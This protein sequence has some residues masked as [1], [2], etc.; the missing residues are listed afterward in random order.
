M[1]GGVAAEAPKAG[2]AEQPRRD[3]DA[4]AAQVD[5]LR[6]ESEAIEAG[7][8]SFQQLAPTR[9]ISAA[10]AAQFTISEN[11]RSTKVLSM[12]SLSFS[13]ISRTVTSSSSLAR[14][15]TSMPGDVVT[16]VSRSSWFETLGKRDATAVTGVNGRSKQY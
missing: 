14:Q 9:K 15:V 16:T 10:G 13:S 3:H 8:R 2:D 4:D 5:R 12:V 1:P 11:P 7:L 6:I